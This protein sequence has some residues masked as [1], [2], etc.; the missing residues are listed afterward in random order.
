MAIGHFGDGLTFDGVEPPV[1]GVDVGEVVGAWSEQARVL[2]RREILGTVPVLHQLQRRHELL[3]RNLRPKA[4]VDQEFR[5]IRSC[6]AT[7]FRFSVNKMKQWSA[8]ALTT[9]L[10]SS[11]LETSSMPA[12][13]DRMNGCW[14]SLILKENIVDVKPLPYENMTILWPAW[15]CQKGRVR[16]GNLITWKYNEDKAKCSF[17][18]LPEFHFCYASLMPKQHI[19]TLCTYSRLVSGLM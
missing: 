1:H 16:S 4:F 9:C 14:P 8:A 19:E 11:F 2:A 6:Q 12:M 10:D 15:T 3:R 17:P 13:F 18:F 7:S 5:F